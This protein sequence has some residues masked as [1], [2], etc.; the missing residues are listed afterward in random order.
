[1]KCGTTNLGQDLRLVMTPQLE[2]A[3]KVLH[4]SVP[5]RASGTD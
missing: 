2:H 1:M 4:L 5:E 3:I